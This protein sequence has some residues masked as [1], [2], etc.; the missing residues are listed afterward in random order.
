MVEVMLAVLASGP[1]YVTVVS[2]D[3]LRVLVGGYPVK[4]VFHVPGTVKLPFDA[5]SE[6]ERVCMYFD[7]GPASWTGAVL[8]ECFGEEVRRI[9]GGACVV[10]KDSEK[11]GLLV[12]GAAIRKV[13]RAVGDTWNGI[14]VRYEA[15][16]PVVPAGGV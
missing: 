12:I 10:L 15:S 7:C 1:C 11:G 3:P 2:R 14:A 9:A 4:P 16:G 8:V 5:K 13:R 6:P